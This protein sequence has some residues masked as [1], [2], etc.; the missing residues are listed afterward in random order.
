MH[1][2]TT[3]YSPTGVRCSESIFNARGFIDGYVKDYYPNGRLQSLTFYSNGL[4][5]GP[6]TSYYENGRRKSEYCTELYIPWNVRIG[7]SREWDRDGRILRDVYRDEH[8]KLH[9]FYYDMRPEAFWNGIRYYDHGV[10]IGFQTL[11]NE[12]CTQLKEDLMRA[13]N[14]PDRITRL[15]QVHGLSAMDYM[16]TVLD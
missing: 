3:L 4:P 9:G 8:G 7:R 14:H 5:D 13:V 2:I 10:E 11:A 15:A 1:S 16:F 12:R 6:A